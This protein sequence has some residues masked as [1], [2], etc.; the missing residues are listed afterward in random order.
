MRIE[1]ADDLPPIEADSIR[2]NQILNNLVSNAVKFTEE[3]AIT[4]RTFSENGWACIEVQDTG[5]GI[6]EED[7]ER[8]FERFR[9]ADGS[10]ARQAEGTGL[11]L[12]ITRNLVELHGGS[13]EVHSKPGEGSTFIVRLPAAPTGPEPATVAD[14]GRILAA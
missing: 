4:I 1:A 11:G 2:L 5:T 7:L 12:A 10:H 9:Q 14:N 6:S 3:G 8:I 13:I